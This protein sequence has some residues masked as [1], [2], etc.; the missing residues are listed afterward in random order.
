MPVTLYEFCR[1]LFVSIA[2]DK[3][4]IKTLQAW[5]GHSTS[6]DTSGTYAHVFK[7]NKDAQILEEINAELNISDVKSDVKV[8]IKKKNKEAL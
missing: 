2:I 1:H 4:P 8:K 3:I 5:I 7:E 6:M